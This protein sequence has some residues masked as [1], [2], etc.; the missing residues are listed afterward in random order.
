MNLKTTRHEIAKCAQASAPARVGTDTYEV[1]EGVDQERDHGDL[2]AQI[3]IRAYELY[4]QRGHRDGCAV[5]DWLDAERE[6][7]GRISS[8]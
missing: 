6:I 3:T 4:V 1:G 2:Q 5:D 7:L 8:P